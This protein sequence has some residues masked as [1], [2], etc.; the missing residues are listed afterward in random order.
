MKIIVG[1]GNPGKK[2][3]QTRHNAGFMAIDFLVE[4]AGGKWKTNKKFNSLFCKI[5]NTLFVK[6]LAFMN[7]SGKSVTAILSY[8][9]L[10]PKTLGI[11]KNK[12]ADLSNILTVIHDDIDIDLGKIKTSLNS[13]S[14]GHKGVQSIIDCLKTKKFKRIR[15]GIAAET[16]KQISVSEFVLKKF[17][18]EEKEIIK[19]LIKQLKA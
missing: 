12:N 1:L 6:P 4:N 16:K 7:N 9:K 15:L 11:L 10:L 19:N 13:G 8:F 5:N 14:A 18:Q 2:Y 17:S 3:E